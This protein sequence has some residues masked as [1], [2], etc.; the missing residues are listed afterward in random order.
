MDFKRHPQTNF[1]PLD[2]LSKRRAGEEVEALRD[3]IAYHD[4]LYY[5]K[6]QP[7]IAD[8]TY[9]KLLRRLQ[10]LEEAFPELHAADS[11][12]QRVGAKPAAKLE[13]VRHS[14]PMLSL[15]ATLDQDEVE[16]FA[17]MV[18][19]ETDARRVQY[20]LE[21]KFDGFSVEVV[22]DHG[23][24]AY[25]ASRGDGETGE[26]I[27]ANLK[28]IRSLPLRLQHFEDGPLRL[29]V[30]GEVLLLSDTT[31]FVVAGANPGRKLEAARHK[32]V[33][34]LDEDGFRALIGGTA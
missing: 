31:D 23:R 14:V 18:Q 17:A 5:V 7:R 4:Y 34:V 11:P 26:D 15:H 10:D 9:D 8:A 6:N 1:T 28:T 22:D 27:S 24:F 19:Q 21:P 25:G 13:K 33:R 20:V 16:R 32:G 3:G 12:T 29:A 30:R 2:Q